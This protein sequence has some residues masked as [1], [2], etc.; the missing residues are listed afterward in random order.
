MSGLLLLT[1][2]LETVGRVARRGEIDLAVA[3]HVAAGVQLEEGLVTVGPLVAQGVRVEQ[4]HRPRAQPHF[5]AVCGDDADVRLPPAAILGIVG[6][7]ALSGQKLSDVA[8]LDPARGFR[9]G[10]PVDEDAPA[11][12]VETSIAIDGAGTLEAHV[13]LAHASFAKYA[14]DLGDVATPAAIRV[15]PRVGGVARQFDQERPGRE[16]HLHQRAA[17]EARVAAI[18]QQHDRRGLSFEG[19]QPVGAIPALDVVA[20]AV[21]IARLDQPGEQAAVAHAQRVGPARLGEVAVAELAAVEIDDRVARHHQCVGLR[22]MLERVRFEYIMAL[23]EGDSS[24][25]VVQA[26]IRHVERGVLDRLP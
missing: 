16:A 8:D 10:Q 4:P 14:D 21:G 7:I 9:G 26:V 13:H 17:V 24:R 3:V 6:R 2:A 19:E 23:Y 12:K 5:E 20:A 25:A 22:D 18:R 1:E 15:D 11:V